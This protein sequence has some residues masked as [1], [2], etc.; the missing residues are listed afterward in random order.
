MLKKIYLF[1]GVCIL[2]A[3]ISGCTTVAPYAIEGLQAVGHFGAFNTS[4]SSGSSPLLGTETE[5]YNMGK[6][7]VGISLGFYKNNPGVIFMA[8]DQGTRTNFVYFEKNDPDDMKM[9][10]D[11]NQMGET[12]KK[13]QIRDWFI[14]YSKLDLGPIES[15]TPKETTVSTPSSLPEN[16]PTP[17]FA[18]DLI[19]PLQ[20]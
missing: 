12:A 9:I 19:K 10:N 18:P 14:K 2:V 16:I 6:Y 13:Q 1:L 4:G 5:R 15:E 7:E 3:S 17:V 11:F 8:Y 20:P